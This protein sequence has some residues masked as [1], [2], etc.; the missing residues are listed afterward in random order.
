MNAFLLLQRFTATIAL[1]LCSILCTFGQETF[2][3]IYDIES[4][5]FDIYCMAPTSDGGYILGG[6]IPH[7]AVLGL[8]QKV[9][10]QGNIEWTKQIGSQYD[11]AVF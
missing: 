11:H 1:V 7:G 4:S 3:K 2:Q 9:D 5:A 6:Q 10:A 8:V